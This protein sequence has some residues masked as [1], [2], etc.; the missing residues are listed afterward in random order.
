[1]CQFF[2]SQCFVQI[3]VVVVAV[4]VHDGFHLLNL[5]KKSMVY[6]LGLRRNQSD[7][8]ISLLALIVVLKL[9]PLQFNF[10]LNLDLEALT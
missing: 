7:H 8:Y 5:K 3:L 6:V 1:M 2:H 10:S 4:V 9:L